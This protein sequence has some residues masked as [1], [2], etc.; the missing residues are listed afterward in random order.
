MKCSDKELSF[1]EFA[2]AFFSYLD[3]F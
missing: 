2:F 1:A 3:A